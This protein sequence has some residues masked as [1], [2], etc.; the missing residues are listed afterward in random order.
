MAALSRTFPKITVVDRRTKPTHGYRAVHIIVE[1]FERA[2]EIQ[3]RTGSQHMWAE[4]SE[5]LSDVL[6]PAIK[7]G[8]GPDQVKGALANGSTAVGAF[9][10]AERAVDLELAKT[11]DSEKAITDEARRALSNARAQLADVKKQLDD[12]LRKSVSA[13]VEEQGPRR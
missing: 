2:V 7:Y 1:L 6:D 9:E 5:K 13:W 8:G 12:A 10:Q 4:L 3:V 11:Q